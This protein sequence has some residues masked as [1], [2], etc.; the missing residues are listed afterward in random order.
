M[1]PSEVSTSVTN[2]AL[3]IFWGCHFLATV[4]CST[5]VDDVGSSAWPLEDVS[6]ILLWCS[7]VVLFDM[8]IRVVSDMETMESISMPL[9]LSRIFLKQTKHQS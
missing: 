6:F 2:R 3:F 5:D 1:P 8:D 7:D 4:G 9:R